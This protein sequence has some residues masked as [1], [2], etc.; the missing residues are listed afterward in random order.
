M[1]TLLEVKGLTKSFG[2]LVAVKDLDFYLAEKEILGIIGPNG[3]GKTTVFN[4]VTGFLKPDTGHIKFEG[5]NI[6]GL[7]PYQINRKGIAR[8]FQQVKLFNDLSVIQNIKVAMATYLRNSKIREDEEVKNILTSTG[9]WRVRDML[10]K[11]IPFIDKKRLQLALALTTK[12]KILLLDEIVAG[13]NP[14]EIN[15]LTG[16]ITK[17][18]EEGKSLLIVEHVMRFVMNVSDRIIVLNYGQKIAEGAPHE[19]ANDAKVIETYLG[20]KYQIA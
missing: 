14:V 17:Y 1:N 4:L 9:L 15:E 2:G 5:E 20:S 7:K 8:T 3:S 16:L 18:R 13:L 10:A 12:P 6:T 11:N 19:I